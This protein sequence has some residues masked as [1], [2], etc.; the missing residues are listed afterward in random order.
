MPRGLSV[1]C[2]CL[3]MRDLATSKYVYMAEGRM[4]KKLKDLPGTARAAEGS[5]LTSGGFVLALHEL[6]EGALLYCTL[7]TMFYLIYTLTQ[8]ASR[9]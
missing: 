6:S 8:R 3:T 1:R 5:Q 2:P 4:V 7:F 9:I